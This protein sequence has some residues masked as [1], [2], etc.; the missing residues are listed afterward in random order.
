MG[1]DGSMADLR[2]MSS[3]MER[4]AA[5]TSDEIV[6]LDRAFRETPGLAVAWTWAY[7]GQI[8]HA[9]NYDYPSHWDAVEASN[10]AMDA[11]R[12]AVWSAA[13]RQSIP[14]SDDP[15]QADLDRRWTR[16]RWNA[17]PE[18]WAEMA[19]EV[20]AA[21]GPTWGAALAVEAFL[22]ANWVGVLDPDRALIR[23][24][25]MVIEPFPGW[26]PRRQEWPWSWPPP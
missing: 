6:A 4:A 10:V 2:P 23:P 20:L 5:L 12:A 8:R 11:S 15:G 14:G 7:A 24:W 19:M 17:S 16:V 1:R 13:R 18:R 21:P 26:V 3:L 22:L 9:N 25:E